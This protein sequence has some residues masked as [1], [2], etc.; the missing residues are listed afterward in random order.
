M[1]QM[2]MLAMI[3]LAVLLVLLVPMAYRRMHPVESFSDETDAYQKGERA[4]YIEQGKA[5][6]NKFADTN[7]IQRGNF[8]HV[9]DKASL[10]AGNQEL[11]TILGTPG[12]EPS[13]SSAT[14]LGILRDTVAAQLPPDSG[15]LK[16]TKKCEAVKGRAGCAVL[17][18]PGYEKCGMCIKEGTTHDGRNEGK[19]IGGLLLIDEDRKQAEAD[20]TPYQPTVGNCPEGYF[21]VNSAACTKAANR[22]NCKEIGETGGFTGGKTAEGV[23]WSAAVGCAQAPLTANTFVY[24]PGKP[25]DVNLRVLAPNG[26]G[27]CKVWINDG[28]K[29]LAYGESVTPGAEFTIL[30]KQITELKP[31]SIVV[32][33]GAPQRPKG[34]TEVFLFEENLIGLSSAGYNQTSGSAAQVCARIGARLASKADLFASMNAGAQ[35]CNT[36]VLTDGVGFPMQ[37]QFKTD[38]GCGTKG[39]NAWGADGG[40]RGNSWCVGIK[41]P[42]STNQRGF[43]TKINPFFE[44]KGDAISPSQAE[45]PTMWSQH[46]VNYQ[47]PAQR[48]ILMQWEMV[49]GA[50]SDGR[51][52][53][54]AAFEP[55]IVS[56][57]G[58][59]ASSVSS[60]G[61]S[62]FKILR[63]LGTFSKSSIING[64][65][66][67]ASSRMATNQFWIWSNLATDQ[68]V[69]FDVKVPGTLADP[70]YTEDTNLNPRGPLL[71]GPDAAAFLRTSPCMKEGQVAGKYSIA[72]LTSLFQSAGGDVAKG[73]LATENGGLGQLNKK[74][75]MDAI[76]GYLNDLYML[77][78]TGKDANG[79]MVGTDSKSNIKAINDAAQL[80]FGF[81]IANPCEDIGQD[82]M[83]NLILT[84]KTGAL[85]SWC[86]DYL[87]MNAGTDQSREQVPSVGGLA[88][89][90][91][92]YVLIA[93]RY[94]GLK[95]KEAT[96]TAR[97]KAPFTTC[98]RTGSMAPVKPSGQVNRKAVDAISAEA[99]KRGM[100]NGSIVQ[101]VQDIYAEIHYFANAKP[102]DNT[103]IDKCYGLAKAVDKKASCGL[104]ARYVRVLPSGVYTRGD[105]GNLCIQIPQLQVFDGD[106]N[107]VAKGKPTQAFNTG[108]GGVKDFAV[109]GNAKNHGHGQGE[110]HS[111]C[112]SG[113]DYEYWMV[114]LGGMMEISKVVFYF[115]NDCCTQ[116]QLAAPVQLLDGSKRIVA[117]KYLGSTTFPNKW[118]DAETLEFKREDGT[119]EIPM[120]SLTAGQ[121]L[122]LQTAT[123]WDRYLRHAGFALWVSA[124][125]PK[126]PDQ[127]LM[128][129][130]TFL[131]SPPNNGKAGYVSLQLVNFP[132]YYLRHSGFRLYA[133]SRGGDQVYKDD[134]S[135]KILPALNGDPTMISLQSSNF[136]DRYLATNRDDPG[137][138]WITPVDLGSLWDK[139]RAS[140]KVKKPLRP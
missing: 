134:S 34:K 119:M 20:H 14:Y 103:A 45:Q 1:H 94:S 52:R 46:G 56:I 53:R 19:H 77:A 60:D 110:Y 122:S 124:F 39:F 51:P 97:A 4:A 95:S 89:L 66:P 79:N 43:Y 104:M 18:T 61:V 2:L 137:S 131:L 115:R 59:G 58:M 98:Q 106:G 28:K 123:S 5:L 35:N 48:G 128:S 6:Y 92:T 15:I 36:G 71:T 42:Q 74:G 129:D 8:L 114:D 67:T 11:R 93:D 138:V 121:K 86:L 50:S 75:D 21:F 108:F 16:D 111:A 107:E 126:S 3:V 91:P 65:R 68:V 109:N 63:R 37:G 13:D 78:T 70:I 83:G 22:A 31:L 84:P 25:F 133:N 120:A 87:W 140:W 85:D 132:N 30:L 64:P 72:C 127:L 112:S 73:K 80:L 47:A 10:D 44:S 62:T 38:G 7:D 26:T 27:V 12:L 41:P 139:Q 116:R 23:P 24:R 105:T 9:D 101:T 29:Q 99:M 113:P 100:K 130:G 117:Q 90:S 32:A 49:G 69:T 102:G 82:S 17:G 88:G 96:P 118:G 55:S 135:F 54:S 76:G 125:N 81:D 136:P 40:T 57:N 33:M